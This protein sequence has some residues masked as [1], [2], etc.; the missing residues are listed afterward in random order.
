[1]SQPTVVS[2]R[3]VVPFNVT[4]EAT[5]FTD[6][7]LCNC[8]FAEEEA[9]VFSEV[10]M[11]EGQFPAGILSVVRGWISEDDAQKPTDRK[12]FVCV[13]LRVYAASVED[14]S[15]TA[16]PAALLTRIVDAMA[17]TVTGEC[18][19]S[20]EGNWKVTEVVPFGELADGQ[21]GDGSV[22]TIR[23]GRPDGEL[24]EKRILAVF[25]PQAWVND[26]A[27]YIDGQQ[28][29]DVTKVVLEMDLQK[30][31]ALRD[32]SDSTDALIDTVALGHNGPFTVRA[33]DSICDFF[34]VKDLSDIAESMLLAA[35]K[36]T[37]KLPGIQSETVSVKVQELSGSRLDWAVAKAL[38]CSLVSAHDHFRRIAAGA[39]SEE[40]IVEHLGKISNEQWI[41]DPITHNAVPIPTFSTSWQSA[42]PIIDRENMWLSSARYMAPSV[43]PDADRAWMAKSLALAPIAPMYG[44]TPHVAAMR[45]Y[46]A[47]KCGEVVETPASLS[48][49]K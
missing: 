7:D 29:V 48:G 36:A 44:P 4:F 1:M 42:G 20:L 32:Y 41:I 8:E 37:L 14:A 39:W 19:V 10:A 38:G 26:Y 11:T 24:L 40:K 3:G 9:R 35:R 16:P 34:E 45:C 31:H 17:S 46:V 33:K 30:I 25:L 15:R 2:R 21:A 18:L 49:R 12:V 43:T 5:G 47:S 6:A 13:T 27:T 23:Q 28:A 22:E